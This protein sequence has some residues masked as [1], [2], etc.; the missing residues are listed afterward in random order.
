MLSSHSPR[1][2]NEANA[3]STQAAARTPPKRRTIANPATVVPTQVSH[4]N[5]LVSQ[6]TMSSRKVANPLKTRKTKFG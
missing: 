1:N 3:P 2:A 4:C 5:R 6:V